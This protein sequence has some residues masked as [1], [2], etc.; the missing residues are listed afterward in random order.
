MEMQTVSL[1]TEMLRKLALDPK[2]RQFTKADKLTLIA[3]VLHHCDTEH[4]KS[5]DNLKWPEGQAILM[6]SSRDNIERTN[7]T[8]QIKSVPQSEF[9]IDTGHDNAAMRRLVEIMMREMGVETGLINQCK[10]LFE[11]KQRGG[12]P[13][14]A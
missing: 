4:F 10:N 6:S 13:I 5:L 7:P 1:C 8:A 11:V 12:F 9:F 2:L 3:G 14:W